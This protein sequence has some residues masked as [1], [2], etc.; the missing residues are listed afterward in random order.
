MSTENQVKSRKGM[1]EAQRK[2]RLANLA[3][4][5]GKKRKQ[6]YRSK[7]QSYD[8]SSDDSYA[9]SETETDDDD[10]FIISRKK[11]FKEKHSK[12][13]NTVSK[14]DIRKHNRDDHLKR[15]VDELKNMIVSLAN[16]Q[17]KQARRKPI[18]KKSGGTKIV[19]LPPNAASEKPQTQSDSVIDALR[20]SLM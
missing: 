11:N 6:D 16:L 12:R 2:A 10:A 5:N 13:N 18:E 20:K 17:K 4:A 7:Q 8:L 14:K 19:V 1:T 3:A 15:E 9:E